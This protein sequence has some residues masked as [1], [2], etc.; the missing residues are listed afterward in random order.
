M[1]ITTRLIGLTV[2]LVPGWPTFATEPNQFEGTVTI[3]IYDFAHV[4][5]KTLTKAE[6]LVTSV[7]TT[8]DIDI[9]WM[10]GS[11]SSPQALV[12]DFSATGK[13]CSKP[14]HSTTVHARILSHAPDGFAQR[15]LGYSLPCA[16]RGTQITIY[17]D[18]VET[19]MH[20][21]L[22]AYYRVL[23]YTLIH[24]LGHVL[25]QSPTHEPNGLMKGMWSKE[26]WQR[27]AVA[28]VPFTLDQARRM[29]ECLGRSETA[30]ALV[31]RH[32]DRHPVAYPTMPIP[33]R[34][35]RRD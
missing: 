6:G 24:E 31:Q 23:G 2:F 28:I 3:A 19:V 30:S 35:R 15:A 8:A 13:G 25:S 17:A 21:T 11:L 4:G 1:M 18:R 29:A 10:A 27:A 22:A 5:S 26:D 34:T 20:Y 33:E 16:E 12:S 9:R 7:F 32:L 14:L